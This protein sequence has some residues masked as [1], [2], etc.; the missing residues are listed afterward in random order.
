MN[1]S[2]TP[3]IVQSLFALIL[4]LLLGA[5]I[6]LE[7]QIRKHP[8][9]LHTNALVCMGS[10]AYVL[11]ALLVTQDSSPTRIAAQVV[12]GVGFICAG[13]I[14]HE[15]ATV[16]GLNTAATIWCTAAIGILAGLNFFLMAIFA[17]VILLV[18]NIA[19]HWVEHRYFNV[20]P[21]Q[22]E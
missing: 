21:P 22:G 1:A 5:A 3:V 20:L 9:G 8:A 13:V 7:R 16:R 11:V 17:T 4:A 14:W 6:G 19:L 15:G 18:A 10:A 12:S 2:L